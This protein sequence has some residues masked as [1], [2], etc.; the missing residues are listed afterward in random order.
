[1]STQKIR[2]GKKGGAKRITQKIKNIREAPLSQDV[3]R[4]V[5]GYAETEAKKPL[6]KI[7][8]PPPKTDLEG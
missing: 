4:I 6:K 5:E 2:I 1:M 7:A 3:F 8:N